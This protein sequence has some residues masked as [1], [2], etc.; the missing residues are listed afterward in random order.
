MTGFESLSYVN[1]FDFNIQRFTYRED[2]GTVQSIAM[3]EIEKPMAHPGNPS[4]DINIGQTGI[5]VSRWHVDG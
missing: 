2:L 5:D 1:Q 3:G 4:I